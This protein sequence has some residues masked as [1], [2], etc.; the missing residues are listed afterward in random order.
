MIDDGADPAGHELLPRVTHAHGGPFGHEVGQ[1]R[2]ERTCLDVTL[3]DVTVEGIMHALSDPLRVT[4]F[5]KIVAANCPQTCSTFLDIAERT[6]PKSTLSQHFKALREAGLIRSER[7]GNE[8]HNTSRCAE[9]DERFPGLIR[10]IVNAHNIQSKQR[11]RSSDPGKRKPAG[12][13]VRNALGAEG[14]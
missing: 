8:L 9:I 7:R 2:D 10:A 1:Q 4:I 12:R 11:Q 14:D 5:A 13:S 3:D 6:V